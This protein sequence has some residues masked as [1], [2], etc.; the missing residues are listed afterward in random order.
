MNFSGL[1]HIRQAVHTLNP[2]HVRELGERDLYVAL[3]AATPD[4]YS[5]L[6]DFLVQGLSPERRRQALSFLH[7]GPDP[8]KVL[9]Y[10]LAVY[11]ESVLAPRRA[12][13]FHADRP[14]R[15]VSSVLDH[16][17]TRVAL[18]LAKNFP[19]FRAPYITRVI[20]T[21]SRENAVFSMATALPDI[22]PS[23]VEI[24]W[25]LT[26]FASD[27]AVLTANQ[28]KMAFILAAASDREVGY[29]E[30]KSEIAML[31]GGAF[32]WR[33]LA[34]QLIGKIP[35]GGGLIPKAAIAYAATKLIGTSLERYYRI[36]YAYTREEREELYTEAFQHGQRVAS[37]ILKKLRPDLAEKYRDFHNVKTHQS[38]SL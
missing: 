5:R 38:T 20:R 37:S 34:R 30:Q 22:I 33:A 14:Q 18:P 2:N 6:E 27:T 11:D 15:L 26:E 12:L 32:G 19:P 3:Y 29:R 16:F 24:P 28:I 4:D 7:R 36:G 1:Q 23:L 35:F 17:D 21:V 9:D 10:D 8:A 13:V 25:A 31:I